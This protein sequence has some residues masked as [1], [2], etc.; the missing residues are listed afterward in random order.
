[1]A[2]YVID[3]SNL[4]TRE[5]KQELD[6]IFVGNEAYNS[7]MVTVM[8]FGF[9]YGTPKD[10]DLVFDVRCLPNPFYIPELKMQTGLDMVVRDYVM[11]F[12]DMEKDIKMMVTPKE[13]DMLIEKAAELDNIRWGR[14]SG[15]FYDRT[16]RR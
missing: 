7:L 14:S 4:L 12:D 3:T 16:Y 13:I 10:S 5:L 15:A 8:S 11:S 1:M 2:D 9:K 6:R